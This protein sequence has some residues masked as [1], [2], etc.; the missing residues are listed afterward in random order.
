MAGNVRVVLNSRGLRRLADSA[1]VGSMLQSK[2]S[3]VLSR[4][5]A[6]SPFETGEYAG[7]FRVGFDRTD[8][9]VIRVYND[10]DHALVVEYGSSRVP[11]YRVLGRA[12]EAAR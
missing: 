1:G 9:R 11:H 5:R 3:T 7:S 6:I 4:A 12:L 8:R 10:A 2:A